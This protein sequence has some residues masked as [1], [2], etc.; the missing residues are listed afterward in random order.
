MKLIS[1]D[2]ALRIF[3]GIL[4]L[5]VLI[6]L[7]PTTGNVEGQASSYWD[8]VALRLSTGSYWLRA[9]LSGLG[10][11]V[12]LVALVAFSSYLTRFMKPPSNIDP[13]GGAERKSVEKKGV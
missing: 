11:A 12:L 13:A 3:V 9:L 5:E 4:A 1:R 7:I 2:I 8:G 6:F 10:A